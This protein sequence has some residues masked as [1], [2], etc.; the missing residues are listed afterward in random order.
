MTAASAKG[1]ILPPGS[2][3]RIVLS[4]ETLTIKILGY[5]NWEAWVEYPDGYR[6]HHQVSDV[7]SLMQ[8]IEGQLRSR[9]NIDAFTITQIPK[10]LSTDETAIIGDIKYA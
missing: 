10:S 1:L 3:P 7:V 5:E 9:Y 2:V 6:R 4:G 8:K